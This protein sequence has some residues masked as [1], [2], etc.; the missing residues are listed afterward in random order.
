MISYLNDV[1]YNN[2]LKSPNNILG[3]EYLK[4]LKKYKSNIIPYSISRFEVEHDSDNI[5]NNIASATAIRN[6][7]K[8]NKVNL[9]KDVV[10]ENTYEILM[11]NIKNLNIITDLSIFEKEIIYTLRIMSI[12]EI[13]NLPDVSEGLE[14]LI[15]KSALCFNNLSDLINN[16][17]SKR[18]T[19]TRIQRILVYA[20]LRISKKDI[21]ISKKVMP[22]VRILG[23]NENG[24]KLVSEISR[25]NPNLQIITSVKNFIDTNSNKD[26][27]IILDKD[28]L[29]TNIYSLY[30]SN[31]PNGMLDFSTKLIKY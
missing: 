16:V 10:P 26:L 3:I 27:K 22:Y 24:K 5:S 28:I 8:N 25:K 9:L 1:N 11:E 17:K 15:K 31:N 19:T 21:E 14:F 7:I 6:L 30:L 29:A 4:S 20:L 2:I 13:R 18:Y 23:F 12:E